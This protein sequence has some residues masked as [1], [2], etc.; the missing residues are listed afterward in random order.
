MVFESPHLRVTLEHGTATL[1]L[2]FPGDP[3][4]ALDLSRLRDLD[5]AVAAVAANRAVRV[6]VVRSAKPAGFCAGLR[7]AVM[8]SLRHPT[9]RANFAWYGQQVFERLAALDAV[10]V[11]YLDGPC[12]GA[13]LELALACDH[14]VCVARPTTHLGFPDTFACFGGSARLRALAGRRA[15]NLIASGETL[16]GREARALGLVDVAC[17]ERRGKIELRTLLDRVESRPIK[18]TR[19]ELLGLADERRAF[20]SLDRGRVESAPEV[21]APALRVSPSPPP[22]LPLPPLPTTIGVLGDDPN[23]ARIAAEAVLRGGSAVVCGNRAPLFAHLDTALARGFVTPLEAEQA[24]LRV[25]ASDALAG[26]DRA[27]LV[28]VADGHD[29]FRLAAVVGPRAVV[30]VI[31]PNLAAR[32]NTHPPV[33]FPHMR[34]VLRISFGDP[35]RVGLFPG[36]GTATDTTDAVAAWLAPFGLTATAFPV[37]AR[38]LPRAA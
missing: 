28:F 17:C 5:A 34:R 12:L 11:A 33:P 29:P 26:F 24:R 1:W 38:L 22:A 14:R 15:A 27:G 9:Q 19:P 37:A 6:L 2:G 16:S 23:A 4:N 30:C 20:A 8:E 3:V 18:P 7:P 32:P 10:T 35:G 31:R 13:G 25:R 21:F 36:P